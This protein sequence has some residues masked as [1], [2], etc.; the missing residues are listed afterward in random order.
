M[1][2]LLLSFVVLTGALVT[3]QVGINTD[4]PEATLDIRAKEDQKGDLRIEGVEMKEKT[5]WLLIWDEKDQKVKRTSLTDLKWDMIVDKGK[6]NYIRGKQPDR[7]DEI[8]N[9]IKQCAP[10]NILFDKHFG[11]GKHD[12][13]YCATTVSEGSYN[14]TWLNLNLGAAYADIHNPNFDPS[15]NKT[16]H[17][18]HS[19][20]NLYGSLYQWQRASDGHEFRNPETIEELAY[21]WTD[22]GEAAGKFIAGDNHTNWVRNGETASGSD[23]ALWRA[24]GANNPCPSGYHVPT[25][26]EWEQ[27]HNVVGSNQMYTQTKLPNLAAAGYY[28]YSNGSL[29]HK[30]SS[31]EYWSSSDHQNYYAHSLNFHSDFSDTYALNLQYFGY[32]VR[33]IKNN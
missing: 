16:S 2:K 4:A 6:I 18:A 29:R 30:D 1:K 27:L 21:T 11:D 28:H 24:G 22:T 20:E 10:E 17:D 19:D 25:V 7:A 31:G 8:I 13:V 5:D 12:F 15:V 26:E 3:A 33:C 9:K 32:S 14:R 23:L